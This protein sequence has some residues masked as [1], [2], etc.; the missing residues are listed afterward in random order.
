MFQLFPNLEEAFVASCNKQVGSLTSA[1]LRANF[2]NTLL[3]KARSL[4]SILIV[5]HHL[6]KTAPLLIGTVPLQGCGEKLTGDALEDMLDTAVRLL[7]CISNTNL[8]T[9][10]HIDKALLACRVVER[11]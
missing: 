3:T 9:L 10:L 4:C 8:S 7:A 5:P 2:C 6:L 11:S 1:E